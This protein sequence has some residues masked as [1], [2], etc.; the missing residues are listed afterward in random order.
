MIGN[1]AER[2]VKGKAAFSAEERWLGDAYA[3]AGEPEFTRG[4][5]SGPAQSIASEVIFHHHLI[6]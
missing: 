2:Q 1:I 6:K 3:R 5:P 4:M